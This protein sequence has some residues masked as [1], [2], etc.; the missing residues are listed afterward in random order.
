[1][2]HEERPLST[3]GHP[4]RIRYASADRIPSVSSSEDRIERLTPATSD[5]TVEEERR[6]VRKLDA[7][8]VLPSYTSPGHP[9]VHHA[10]NEQASSMFLRILTG[11]I[12]EM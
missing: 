1:M 6:L 12:W 11:R 3:E 7:R 8:V 5:W 9:S 4:R 10:A 2:E